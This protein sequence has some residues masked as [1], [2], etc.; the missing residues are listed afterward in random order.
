[1]HKKLRLLPRQSLSSEKI[2]SGAAISNTTNT[3]DFSILEIG[4]SKP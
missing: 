3:I 2:Y 4:T 1:M